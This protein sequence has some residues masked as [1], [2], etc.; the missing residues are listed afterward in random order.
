MVSITLTNLTFNELNSTVKTIKTIYKLVDELAPAGER[1]YRCLFLSQVYDFVSRFI[2]IINVMFGV[3]FY[4]NQF[5]TLH[6]VG[7]IL[8][9]PEHRV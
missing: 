2:I 9:T 4:N 1:Y 5:W 8:L 7:N 6:V 3:L